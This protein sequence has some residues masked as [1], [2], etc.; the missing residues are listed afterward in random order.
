MGRGR[1]RRQRPGDRHRRQSAA[2][3]I[4]RRSAPPSSLPRPARGRLAV[5]ARPSP[6]PSPK[7]A[8]VTSCC[9]PARDMKPCR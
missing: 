8:G 7:R 6:Q 9:W 1:G 2:P 3:K 4:R 5:G